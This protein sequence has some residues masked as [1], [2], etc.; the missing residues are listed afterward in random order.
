MDP[1]SWT[2]LA[3]GDDVAYGAGVWTGAVRART[4][5]PLTPRVLVNVPS[6]SD[7][8]RLR[9]RIGHSVDARPK[10][11]DAWAVGPSRG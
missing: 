9:D 5:A 1:I 10:P 8:R 2:L 11:A 3:I 7:V 4:V 6:A